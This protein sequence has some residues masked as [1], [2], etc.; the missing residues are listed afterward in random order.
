M[1]DET[2]PSKEG[3]LSELCSFLSERSKEISDRYKEL[4]EQKYWWGGEFR[5][6]LV[7][8]LQEAGLERYLKRPRRLT[9][10]ITELLSYE[11][12]DRQG[13]IEMLADPYQR[14]FLASLSKCESQIPLLYSI[15][16]EHS[17]HDER[18]IKDNL[19]ELVKS[20]DREGR[21]QTEYVT[22]NKSDW[23][24]GLTKRGAYLAQAVRGIAKATK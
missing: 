2:I 4:K 22:F 7:N 3:E 10:S 6:Y 19:S 9:R 5:R 1:G 11:T 12:D 17:A 15:G 23:R 13:D 14:I 8:I 16:V 24:W 18:V 20:V 21:L